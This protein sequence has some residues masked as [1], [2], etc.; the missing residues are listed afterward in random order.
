MGCYAV[1]TG[2]ATGILKRQHFYQSTRRNIPIATRTS[3]LPDR[4]VSVG[5]MYLNS[6][7]T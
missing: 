5:Q 3:N 6:D 7:H 2:K 1:S 4:G